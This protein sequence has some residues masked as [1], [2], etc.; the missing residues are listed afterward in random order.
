MPPPTT[1]AV[2]QILRNLLRIVCRS[3]RSLNRFCRIVLNHPQAGELLRFLFLGSVV[4]TGRA[5]VQ[6][7]PGYVNSFIMVKAHFPRGDTTYEWAKAY[8]QHHGVW[9]HSAEL[10]VTAQDTNKITDRE[11]PFKSGDGYL[12][13]VYDPTW[14]TPELFYWKKQHWITV[15]MNDSGLAIH[16]WGWNRRVLD[17]FIRAAREFYQNREVP[18]PIVSGTSSLAGLGAP[19]F[20]RHSPAPPPPMISTWGSSLVSG[21]FQPG[22]FSYTWIYEYLQVQDS[23]AANNQMHISTRQSDSEWSR[24]ENVKKKQHVAAIPSGTLRFR[25]RS[26]W[27]QT[28]IPVLQN[29]GGPEMLSTLIILIHTCDTSVL[30]DFIEDARV[31]YKEA[32]VSRVN[33]HL[34]NFNHWG[35]VVAK[36]RRSFSTLILPDGEKENLLSDVQDFLDNEKWYT[37][38]GVPHRRGYLLYGDPGTGKSTTVHALAGELGMEIYFISLASPGINDHTLGDLFH[39]TP[40]HSILLIEDIDCAFSSRTE[41][42][43]NAEI[44]VD[45][46]GRPLMVEPRSSVTLSGLLNILDSVASQEGR[47]LFA[48]TNHIEQLDPALI[49]PGR[50]DVKIK[51]SLATKEQMENVFHWFYPTNSKPTLE[52]GTSSLPR[53][54]VSISETQNLASEFATA[55][56][57]SK[58]SI[59]QLQGYLL[60]WKNNP[61]GAVQGISAWVTEREAEAGDIQKLRQ[62]PRR[63]YQVILRDDDSDY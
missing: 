38:A 15:S 51:Y 3:W 31:H 50:I 26:Y 39:S 2:V 59:A 13:A 30:M 45:P 60:G 46:D 6:K 1:S 28:D 27:V 18:P 10:F 32:S 33:V 37:F 52:E 21:V 19:A 48:T 29:G 5:F 35:R 9:S 54:D 55:I 42:P 4:E 61:T 47:I 41:E 49:R 25:W 53:S 56:P 57:E 43:R 63:G 62:G 11:L 40:A 14:W 58:Y 23:V 22:D 17:D 7:I 34:T 36:T 16:V 20:G 24:K 12:D 8:L 44:T